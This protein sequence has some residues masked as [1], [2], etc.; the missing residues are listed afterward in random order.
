MHTGVKMVVQS[1]GC[2]FERWPRLSLGLTN[3]T[4]PIYHN[5][6]FN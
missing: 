6:N 4:S 3:D 1:C 2:V 5:R